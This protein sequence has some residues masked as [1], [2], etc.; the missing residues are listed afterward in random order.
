MFLEPIRSVIQARNVLLLLPPLLAA[1]AAL[2]SLILIPTRRGRW[3]L[4]C[5]AVSSIIWGTLDVRK[6]ARN[7]E[8]YGEDFIA[9]ARLTETLPVVV[10]CDDIGQKVVDAAR[11]LGGPLTHEVYAMRTKFG[12]LPN[13]RDL[14]RGVRFYA[15]C[16]HCDK[17]TAKRLHRCSKERGM[18]CSKQKV[19]CRDSAE[20]CTVKKKRKRKHQYR[21]S[22]NN[23]V[24]SRRLRGPESAAAMDVVLLHAI[25]RTRF[26]MRKIGARLEKAGHHAHPIGYPSTRKP[27]H[28]LAELILFKMDARGLMKD[29]IGFVGHSMGGVMLRALYAGKPDLRVGRAVLIGA[30][31]TGSVIADHADWLTRAWYGPALA[32]LRTDRVRTL[33]IIKAPAGM[34]AGTRTSPFHPGRLYLERHAPNEPNDSAVLLRETRADWL[35]EHTAVDVSHTVLP[36]DPQVIELTTRYLAT[37]TFEQS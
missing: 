8:R 26:S 30:P 24:S 35:H 36:A 12:V 16:L 37:G 32:D 25:G 10:G 18:R 22:R 34:I 13:A 28:E 33:P 6:E 7:P 27:M 11:F 4:G 9:A 23:L 29:E 17:R 3:L 2:T 1:S 5:A 21:S 19:S 31:I 20:R 14:P 15:A